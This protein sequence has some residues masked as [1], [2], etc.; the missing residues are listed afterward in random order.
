MCWRRWTTAALTPTLTPALILT[1]TLIL[2][3]WTTAALTP[4]LALALTLTPTL[5]LTRWTT[6]ALTPTL[7]LAL[8]LTPAL[9]LTRW[10][11][12]AARRSRRSAAAWSY[13]KAPSWWRHSSPRHPPAIYHPSTPASGRKMC[14]SSR[15]GLRYLSRRL[16]LSITPGAASR[17][18]RSSCRCPRWP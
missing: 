17:L 12:A 13:S 16:P 4:A 18:W 14:D 5:T 2:T 1:P 6:A 10:T 8:I 9:T 7:T 11:T 15:A 3:R